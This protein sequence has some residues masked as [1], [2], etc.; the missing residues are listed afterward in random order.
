MKIADLGSFVE[1]K[2]LESKHLIMVREKQ[3]KYHVCKG[4]KLTN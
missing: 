4:I 3:V 1:S 2:G